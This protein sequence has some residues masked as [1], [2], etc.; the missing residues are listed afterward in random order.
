M[1]QTH[2]G[3]GLPIQVMQQFCPIGAHK[4]FLWATDD[5]Q[6]SLEYWHNIYSNAS[7]WTTHLGT[8]ARLSGDINVHLAR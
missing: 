1:E 8:V 2:T 5:L 6:V 4:A 7:C 3:V